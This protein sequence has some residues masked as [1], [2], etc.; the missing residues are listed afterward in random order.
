MLTQL[1]QL[2]AISETH[3]VSHNHQQSFRRTL[4][5]GQVLAQALM[6]AGLTVKQRPP[7]SLHA[8]F[9]RAGVADVPI[10]YHVTFLR[11]GKSVS[12]RSVN[13]V[14]NE[15]LLFTM[16]ASFH[17]AEQGFHHQ[18]QFPQHNIAPETLRQAPDLQK[19]LH[20]AQ[21]AAEVM[22]ST[23]L[24]LVP[25]DHAI[26]EEAST[27]EQ[28]VRFWVRSADP[29]PNQALQHYCAL[30]FASDVGLLAAALLPHPTS[31]FAGEVF[32]ASMDHCL[33]F[34]QA[35]DFNLWHQYLTA[36]PWAGDGR[37]LC[38]GALFN[39]SNELVA[40]VN[41]EGLIRPTPS[42]SRS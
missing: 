9:L 15:Q 30:A 5:G 1:L 13:A 20:L 42:G 8:Y 18:R 31:L 26:F 39:A 14:Q 27:E 32:P 23:P 37:A 33:W 29:L 10:E 41:Q 40:S 11:D 24:E 7:N 25:Y 28:D 35:T 4:F 12:T 19:D 2:D 16:Q 6:A 17:Q 38:R 36:S 21:R 34:H 3:F 22:G